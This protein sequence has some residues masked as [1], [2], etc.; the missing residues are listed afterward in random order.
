MQLLTALFTITTLFS[1]GNCSCEDLDVCSEIF[2]AL[3]GAL[4]QDKGNLYRSRK[5]FFYVPS[6]DPVLL[7]VEYNIIFAENITEDRCGTTHHT[8]LHKC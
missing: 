7:R 5:T 8:L 4:I 2:Q 3:E 6:A 1:V